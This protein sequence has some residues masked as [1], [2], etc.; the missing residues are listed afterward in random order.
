MLKMEDV[1][2]NFSLNILEQVRQSFWILCE[3][4]GI[5]INIFILFLSSLGFPRESSKNIGDMEH[6]LGSGYD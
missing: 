5:D 2:R 4:G 1:L 6:T 3:V